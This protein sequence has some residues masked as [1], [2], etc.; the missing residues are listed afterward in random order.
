M[1]P[2]SFTWNLFCSNLKWHCIAWCP[3]Y[4]S[5]EQDPVIW[6]FKWNPFSGTITWY[7]HSIWYEDVTFELVNKILRS[8][9]SNETL[10][11]VLSHS[12]VSCQ[13]YKKKIKILVHM[14]S[15]K[16]TQYY[17]KIVA[18][19]YYTLGVT[20]T[21]TSNTSKEFYF[22]LFSRNYGPYDRYLRVQR[23][24]SCFQDFFQ[25]PRQHHQPMLLQ[26]CLQYCHIN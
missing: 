18:N 6:P 15:F 20:V 21:K 10:S 9:H 1:N 2:S 7:Y 22:K 24:Q 12:T 3:N 25:A 14:P 13:V 23:W 19:Y 8:Y 16:K 11:V 5:C 26:H 4:W 17:I